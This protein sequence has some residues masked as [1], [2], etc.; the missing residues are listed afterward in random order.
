[1]KSLPDLRLFV[2]A[3]RAGSL[4][5]AAR[6]LDTTPA[7]ASLALKRLEQALGAPLFVR[8]TRSLRL[9]PEGETFLA[10]CEQALQALDDGVEAVAG[11]QGVVRG[12]LALTAPSDLGRN[13][14]LPWLDA[15]QSRHPALRIR[16]RT[17]DRLSDLYREPFD[18][19]LRYG[20]P[21]DSSMVALPLAPQNR[22]VLCAAPS[23]LER[24]GP[25][26]HP[27]ELATRNCLCFALGD[28]LHDQWRFQGGDGECVVDVRGDRMSD[29]G[30]IV[31]RWAL[32]GHGIVYKSALD[33]ADD[34][35]AGRLVALCA[36][37][38][39]ESSPLHLVCADRRS[40][41]AAIRELRALIEAECAARWSA[42]APVLSPVSPPQA[43]P[44]R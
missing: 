20:N 2:R 7:A 29:D 22:R 25:L 35:V 15:F 23:Y 14:I 31:R 32:A 37:W 6:Q 28:D 42:L 33:V 24:T 34:L 18:A 3:A 40:L 5:A 9:T 39:G 19:A 4:T 11:G 26:R 17:T 13:V 1:M 27:Q 36:G 21:A 12:T 43:A 41:G 44:R 38:R 8:S 10:H 30:D 16:L